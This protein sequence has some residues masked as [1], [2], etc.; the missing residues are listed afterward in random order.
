MLNKIQIIGRVGKDPEFKVSQG[1]TPVCRFSVATTEKWKDKQTGEQNEETEWHRCLLFQR[2][3][4]T[5]R[6]Y[7]YKGQL[8][9]IEGKMHYDSYENKEGQK[10]N[11]AEIRVT[12]MKFLSYKDKGESGSGS[13]PK[14]APADKGGFDDD[15]LPF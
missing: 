6:D 3:A 10:V 2:L 13:A 4:E 11:T 9:Y 14:P 15:D 5:A 8:I 7:V 12:E 1:G